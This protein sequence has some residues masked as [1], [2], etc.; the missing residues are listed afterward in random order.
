[1]IAKYQNPDRLKK[2]LP[3]TRIKTQT[4]FKPGEESVY[5]KLQIMLKK[6]HDAVTYKVGKVESY[7]SAN[8][9]GKGERV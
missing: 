6:G 2:S 1:M 4:L 3:K 7:L 9:Q 8:M 5:K